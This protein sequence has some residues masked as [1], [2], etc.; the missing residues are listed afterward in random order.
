M[1]TGCSSAFSAPV[2][3]LVTIEAS[4]NEEEL[5]DF[6]VEDSEEEDLYKD[7][8]PDDGEEDEEEEKDGNEGEEKEGILRDGNLEDEEE[9]EPD[10]FLDVSFI[11]EPSLSFSFSSELLLLEGSKNVVGNNQYI[12]PP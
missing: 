12:F 1:T 3:S 5:S 11:E 10:E 6:D 2:S 9:D 8:L 4:G 7:E